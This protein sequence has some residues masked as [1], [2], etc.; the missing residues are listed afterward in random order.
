MSDYDKTKVFRKKNNHSGE[1]IISSKLLYVMY[2]LSQIYSYNVSEI[3]GASHSSNSKHYYGKAIHISELNDQDIGQGVGRNAVCH[4]PNKL[5]L[6]FKKEALRYG[7]KKILHK[8]N[9]KI[10]KDHHN[11]F[12][13]VIN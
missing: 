4:I 2:K 10:K 3:T 12:H 11:H 1:V 9:R 5:I 7:A 13:T 8:L 6:E